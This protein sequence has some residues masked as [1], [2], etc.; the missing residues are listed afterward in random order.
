[1]TTDLTKTFYKAEDMPID[2]LAF[3]CDTLTPDVLLRIELH[4][5]RVGM[6]DKADIVQSSGVANCG[7]EYDTVI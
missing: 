4:L 7:S 1:M 2:D 3:W 6:T 5:R